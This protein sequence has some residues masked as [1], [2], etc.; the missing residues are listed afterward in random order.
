[1][2]GAALTL[3][4]RGVALQIMFSIGGE[5]DLTERELPHLSGWRGS[6]PVRIGNGAWNLPALGSELQ[7]LRLRPGARLALQLGD[8]GASWCKLVFEITDA[9]LEFGAPR[10]IRCHT[11]S[12]QLLDVL[13]QPTVLLGQLADGC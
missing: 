10:S 4:R 12:L 1:M 11:C 9:G 5:H 7:L 2:T 8:A 6:R 3:M 13:L